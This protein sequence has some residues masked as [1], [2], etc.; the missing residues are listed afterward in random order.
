MIFRRP[1][2]RRGLRGFGGVSTPP[3]LKLGAGTFVRASSAWWASADAQT[4]RGPYGNNVVRGIGGGFVVIEG[5]VTNLVSDDPV[6]IS[7]DTGDWA[8][9]GALT[10]EGQVAT[11]PD[12]TTTASRLTFTASAADR[13]H[14]QASLPT[15]ST[16]QRLSVWART[17]SGTKD[18]RIE[19]FDGVAVQSSSDLT[20][21]TTW[22]RFTATFTTA[23]SPSGGPLFRIRNNTAG[24]AGSI[25]V[26]GADWQQDVPDLHPAPV[27]A[28]SGT[29][30]VDDLTFADAD[31]P[32]AIDNDGFWFRWRPYHSDTEWAAYGVLGR[33]LDRTVPGNRLIAIA[34]SAAQFQFRG[35]LGTVSGPFLTWAAR[36]PIAVV[37]DH[38][39]GIMRFHD[40]TSAGGDPNPA[41]GIAAGG[42]DWS[43][44]TGELQVGNNAA[45]TQ[46]F[47]GE[48]SDIYPLATAPQRAA[49]QL[50]DDATFVRASSA[51]TASDDDQE[52]SSAASG[53]LRASL[54]DPT[55]RVIEG[56]VTNLVNDDPTDISVT[57]G[58]S[59]IG[60]SV[61]ENAGTAPDGSNNAN[62]LT[63]GAVSSD[64]IIGG[65]ATPAGSTLTRVSCWVR[66][67]SGTKTFRLGMNDGVGIQIT[68]NFTATTTWQRF[69]ATFT[70]N[71]TPTLGD[72]R[73]YN[74]DDAVAGSVLVW[75]YD[76]QQDNAAVQFA[77]VLA[78]SAT[79]A[80]DNLSVAGASVHND[81]LTVGCWFKI[82][83]YVDSD[84][85][86]AFNND[87]HFLQF[88]TSNFLRMNGTGAQRQMQFR[89]AG[90]AAISDGLA[91]TWDRFQEITIVIDHVNKEIRS[92][93]FTTGDQT[94][95]IS[96]Q[97][98]WS[99]ASGVDMEIGATSVGTGNFYGEISDFYPLE[100]AP[101]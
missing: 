74:G 15:G 70:T 39:T 93:G 95:D 101:I 98:D 14:G 7:N 68:S 57:G 50:L 37:V 1:R 96:G 18:F 44:C 73:I 52:V 90:A 47:W 10:S 2:H 43:D 6:D 53:E 91:K 35:T 51:W 33:L 58:W 29:K 27:L 40:V 56:P 48:I 19:M 99:S 76:Q 42:G 75:G 67:E 63:F 31:V 21:T 81:F 17:E 66:T 88:G 82:R 28:A 59:P 77:P 62:R 45:L 87:M 54:T 78:A 60:L 34:A 41:F 86:T 89:A 16:A 24:D 13:I 5:A 9:T 55:M 23:A 36:Q 38:A 97:A 30:A 84:D 71:T 64:R 85:M 46:P 12:G 26:W 83:F 20:A 11:A 92:S 65:A 69:T 49:L 100:T 72:V 8:D 94:W 32:A 3:L 61:D 4:V 79:K 25:L 22:Q 80:Y